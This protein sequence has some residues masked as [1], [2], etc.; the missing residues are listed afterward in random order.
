MLLLDSKSNGC[1]EK[2]LWRNAVLQTFHVQD[3]GAVPN[4]M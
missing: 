3:L 1:G 4:V 2:L